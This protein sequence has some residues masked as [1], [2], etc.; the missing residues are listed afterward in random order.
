MQQI[1]FFPAPEHKVL[2]IDSHVIFFPVRGA[3]FWDAPTGYARDA[4]AW[5]DV[6][7]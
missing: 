1:I 3:F 7:E 5:A 6:Y 4:A 2:P